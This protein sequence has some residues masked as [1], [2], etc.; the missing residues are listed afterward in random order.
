RNEIQQVPGYGVDVDEWVDEEEF[1][2]RYN[3]APRTNAPVIRRQNG[4]PSED[5]Q[6]G[7]SDAASSQST[8]YIMQT[9]KWGLIPH[10][11]KFEN[12]SLNTINARAENLIEGHGMWTSIKGKKRCAIPCQGY[13]EWQ[14][15]GKHKQ[16]FFTKRSDGQLL[17]MAG[18]YDSVV[19]EGATT[20]L[21]LSANANRDFS[22]LHDRQPV[23]LKNHDEVEQWLDTT[24]QTWT[25]QLAKMVQPLNDSTLPL[26]CYAVPSDVGKIGKESPTFIEPV[27]K[28]KDGLEAMFSK[29]AAKATAATQPSTPT[30][31]SHKRKKKDISSSPPSAHIVKQEVSDVSF[32]SELPPPEKKPKVEE[33]SW[34]AKG[35]GKQASDS[36]RKNSKGGNPTITSFFK[37][38]G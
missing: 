7:S 13:Y 33:T 28:R 1:I 24:S 21:C 22:W 20:G 6:S 17:L 34:S 32:Q 38:E 35:K 5:A 29:Q 16:P 15:K 12:T 19:L 31:S 9:M 25:A 8:K 14:T 26:E 11:S 3:I 37:K 2:P 23:F 27:A 30:P 10:W 18:L 36:P 4:G